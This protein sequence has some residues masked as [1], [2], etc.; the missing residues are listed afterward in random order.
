MDVSG[1]PT[2]HGLLPDLLET[3]LASTGSAAPT[4]WFERLPAVTLIADL[5]GFTRLAERL[6]ASGPSGVEELS[7]LVNVW[8]GSMVDVIVAHGGDVIRFAGDAPIVIFA[9]HRGS[10][11]ERVANATACGWA[12]QKAIASK[13]GDTPEMSLRVGIA[14]GE[15]TMATIGGV[16]DRW[17]FVVGGPP[18]DEMSDA[19]RSAQR[20]QVVVGAS[21]PSQARPIDDLGISSAAGRGPRSIDTATVPAEGAL[22]PFVSRTVLRFPGRG[23]VSVGVRAQTGQRALYRR[24]RHRPRGFRR[25]RTTPSHLSRAAGHRVRVGRQYYAA[26]RRR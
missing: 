9:D 6:A 1:I 17:E 5:S 11:D 16:E 22:R 24:P 3:R 18:L 26:G 25:A 15:V 14:H 13:A 12:L 2:L 23:P 20:G 7:R 4:F 21:A 8:F 10:L 19:L